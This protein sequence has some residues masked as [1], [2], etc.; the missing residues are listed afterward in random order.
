MAVLGDRVFFLTSDAHLIALHAKTGALLWDVQYANS[1]E[2][3]SATL[4]PL[5]I[6]GKVIVGVGG[7]DCGI[8]GF[9]TAFDASTGKEVWRFW[10]IPSPGESGSETWG[11]HPPEIS[12][13]ATWMTGVYD[14]SQYLVIWTTGNPGP[15]FFGDERPGDNL[16]TNIPIV[17]SRLKQTRGG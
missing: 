14:A 3:Y 12:G 9:V 1:D 11:G 8:R 10:T 6:H 16:Y 7:G 15:D 17:S 5:A 2:N 4:A 13:G